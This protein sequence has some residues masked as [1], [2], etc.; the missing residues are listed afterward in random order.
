MIGTRRVEAVRRRRERRDG[1]GEG[2]DGKGN[3][4]EAVKLWAPVETS[5][6]SRRRVGPL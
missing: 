2:S 3:A 6:Y 5:L 1:G 4:T